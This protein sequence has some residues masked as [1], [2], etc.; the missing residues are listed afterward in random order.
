[1]LV[2]GVIPVDKQPLKV[3]MPRPAGIQGEVGS[4]GKSVDT[5]DAGV[6]LGEPMLL[7]LPRLVGEPDVVLRPLVLA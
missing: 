2:L 7:K 4:F 1:M 6:D 5:P 3:P